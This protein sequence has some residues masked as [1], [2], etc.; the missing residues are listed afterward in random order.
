MTKYE[1]Q[2]GEDYKTI[3]NLF[4]K[5]NTFWNLREEVKQW[6]INEREGRENKISVE[7]LVALLDIDR[8]Y[9]LGKHLDKTYDLIDECSFSLTPETIEFS[10]ERLD[11]IK[12][13][14]SLGTIPQ[15]SQF[16]EVIDSVENSISEHMSN[17]YEPKPYDELL[18]GLTERDFE[19]TLDKNLTLLKHRILELKYNA[20]TEKS[21]G[22]INSLLSYVNSLLRGQEGINYS[23]EQLKQGEVQ[24]FSDEVDK[25][26][27]MKEKHFGVESDVTRFLRELKDLAN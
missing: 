10:K 1:D 7:E 22:Q 17:T 14:V 18:D 24:N 2:F 25:L 23:I 9:G 12:R 13:N 3:F 11:E 6:L 26:I 20:P 27:S 15:I 8:I 5:L 21:K 16:H 19:N 4:T